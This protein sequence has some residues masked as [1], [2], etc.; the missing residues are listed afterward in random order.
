MAPDAHAVCIA[1]VFLLLVFRLPRL[2]L[3]VLQGLALFFIN[4]WFKHVV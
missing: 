2:A 3:L 4:S 1:S